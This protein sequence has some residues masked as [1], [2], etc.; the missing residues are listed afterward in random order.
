MKEDQYQPSRCVF[1]EVPNDGEG[2]AG[3]VELEA[4]NSQPTDQPKD[5]DVAG[6]RGTRR[7]SRGVEL[8]QGQGPS[9][10]PAAGQVHADYMALV[11]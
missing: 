3:A 4:I 8:R 2:G 5:V 11:G 10:L 1:H 6:C 9:A 7:V